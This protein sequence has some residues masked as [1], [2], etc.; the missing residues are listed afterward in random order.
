MRNGRYP[1]FLLSIILLCFS[2]PY[3][4]ETCDS[5]AFKE[6]NRCFYFLVPMSLSG[7][8]LFH[9]NF[10][11]CL[12]S[13]LLWNSFFYWELPS[14]S[15]E[16]TTSKHTCLQSYSVVHLHSQPQCQ[17]V[18]LQSARWTHSQ[19]Q[20]HVFMPSCW[21]NVLLPS[22]CNVFLHSFDAIY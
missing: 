4:W 7:L 20:K 3:A 17:I 8:Q 13:K 9:L 11:E 19:G 15:T 21:Q 10:L 5:R 14:A 18:V 6:I 12:S 22:S 2:G 16:I 1:G